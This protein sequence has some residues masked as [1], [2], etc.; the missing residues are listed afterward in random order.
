T[1]SGPGSPADPNAVKVVLDERANALYFSRALVPFPRDLF[2]AGKADTIDPAGYLLHL[3]IYAFRR[4]TLLGL[5]TLK[6]TVIEQTER[7]E[8]LR[9]LYHGHRIAV[10]IGSRPSTGIDTPEDYAAFVARARR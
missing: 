4:E 8:Q 1:R 9:W 3:G 5:A 2:S 10:A 7:L 6:P